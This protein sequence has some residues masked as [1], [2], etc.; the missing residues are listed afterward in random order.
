MQ[1]K[2]QDRKV[3]GMNGGK[4]EMSIKKSIDNN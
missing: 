4:R 3:S 2:Q 1:S